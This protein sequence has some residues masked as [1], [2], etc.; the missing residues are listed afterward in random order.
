[1]E[2]AAWNADLND[3]ALN[4]NTDSRTI[5][6]QASVFN[7]SCR[8]FAPR[9]RQA[10]LK[11]F[12]ASNSPEAKAALELAYQDVKKAFQYYLDHENHGR[13]II[14]ASHSQG[15]HHAIR[16]LRE[17]F[18]GS[19]LQK[20]LVAAYIIGYQVKKDTFA[21]IPPCNLPNSTGCFITWRSF[22]KGEISKT[23][24][25][26]QGNSVCT[27]P[28]TWTASNPIADSTLNTGALLGGFN[29]LHTHAVGAEVEP[30]AKILWVTVP[31]NIPDKYKK[32]KNLHVLDYNLFWM[33]IRQN[34]R[35][36]V[37][38]FFKKSQDASG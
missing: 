27:N 30:S 23:A 32:I 9:Y 10:N 2:H 11:A 28:L 33:N 4:N 3:T 38:T 31:S 36:R 1:M 34:V 21:H 17:F 6:Y 25:A 22:Q 7:G 8:I 18:D 15:T 37:D 16:L 35:L 24:K 19:P 29:T 14:I 26:E 12:I 5:L 13:P 20:Q